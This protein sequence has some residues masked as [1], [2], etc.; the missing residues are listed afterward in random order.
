MQIKCALVS[1]WLTIFIMA[2]KLQLRRRRRSESIQAKTQQRSRLRKSLF[3]K[4]AQYSLECESD[5]FVMIRTRKNG[6]RFTFD[7]SVSERWLPSMPELVSGVCFPS[8]IAALIKTEWILSHTNP[9][10][11]GRY[12]L[13]VWWSYAIGSKRRWFDVW[14]SGRERSWGSSWLP[15][16]TC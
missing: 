5:V 13:R 2:Q 4:A 9:W 11:I 6:Q 7:S 1:T 3:K 14:E 15:A 12:R 10:D 16:F 8:P